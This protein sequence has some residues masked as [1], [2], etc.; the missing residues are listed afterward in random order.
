MQSDGR[1]SL[2]NCPNNLNAVGYL[3]ILKNYE[4]KMNFE[5]TIAK[6][7][8]FLGKLEKSMK[9]GMKLTQMS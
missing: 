2:F 3:E 1:K 8:S 5:T 6:T 9:F 4:E 7:D